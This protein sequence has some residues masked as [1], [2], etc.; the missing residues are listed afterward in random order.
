MVLVLSAVVPWASRNAKAFQGVD[1][2]GW[3]S[4]VQLGS[5]PGSILPQPYEN[6]DSL[7]IAQLFGVHKGSR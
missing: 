3:G 7:A 1:Q 5:R 4:Q 6:K 2:R